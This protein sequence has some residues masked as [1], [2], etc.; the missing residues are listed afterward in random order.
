MDSWNDERLDELSGRVDAGFARVDQ[1]FERLEGEV[2]E[3][4]AKIDRRFERVEAE[5]KG[6]ATKDEL[7][8]GLKGL[9]TKDELKGLATKEELKGL[10]T[11]DELKP[12]AT[13]SELGEVKVE[14]RS[15]NEKFDRLLLVLMAG[16]VSLGITVLATLAGL[17]VTQT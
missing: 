2:K 6:L 10:A 11:K 5:I 13:K 8:D 1:R 17:V 4:F 3:G 15:L 9:A 7:K 12:L 16:G 14:L